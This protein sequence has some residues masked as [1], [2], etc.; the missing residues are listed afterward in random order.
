MNMLLESAQE[1][2][3]TQSRSIKCLLGGEQI[4]V[5]L[6]NLPKVCQCT[7]GSCF[8]PQNSSNCSTSTP[9]N[10]TM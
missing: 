5:R 1:A 9:T 4:Y 6:S 8:F 3:C 2:K 7:W 10:H